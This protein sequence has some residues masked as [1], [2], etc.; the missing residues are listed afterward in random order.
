MVKIYLS[1]NELEQ[2]MILPPTKEELVEAWILMMEKGFIFNEFKMIVDEMKQLYKV[3]IE[4]VLD[5]QVIHITKYQNDEYGLSLSR[6]HYDINVGTYLDEL[7]NFMLNVKGANNMQQLLSNSK[8]DI[9]DVIPPMS[10]IQY[11]IWKSKYREIEYIIPTQR[12]NND[13]P[14]KTI[15]KTRKKNQIYSL[16]DCI[17]IYAKK[18]HNNGYTWHVES[19]Q[20]RGT[21]RHLKNGKVVPVRGT[22]VNPKGKN[23]TVT[24]KSY[25][26]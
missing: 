3:K 14:K 21:F 2:T 13:K 15:I 8:N 16:L 9:I 23:I 19:F 17:K 10:F 24:N 12:K 7:T 26:L 11:I 20:R 25:S 5:N 4:G 6:K 1:L 18:N 22:T